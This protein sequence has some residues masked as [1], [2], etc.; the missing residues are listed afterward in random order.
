MMNEANVAEQT[1]IFDAPLDSQEQA[2]IDALLKMHRNNAALTQQLALDASR[3]VATSQ[4]RLTRQKEA[5]FF[6]RLTNAISGKTS[7]N[8]LLNQQAMLQMQRFSWHYLQQLQQQNLLNAQSIAVI[9]NNLGTMNDYIIETRG[10]LERAVDKID[11]RLRR[12]E[13]STDFSNWALN[14][15]ANKRRFKSIPKGLLI[16]RLTYDFMRLHKDIELTR[17]DVNHLITTLQSLDVD[18]D[19][20][21]RLLDFVSELIDQ[22]ELTGIEQYHATIELSFD[23]HTVDS[24]FIQKNISGVGFNALYFLAEHYERIAALIGDDELCNNDEAREKLISKFFGNELPGLS[25]KYSIRDLICEI[26]G[27]G[28]LCIDIYKDAH[29]LN[30]V[31]ADVEEAFQPEAVKLVSSLPDIKAHTFLDTSDDESKRNYLLLLA[32]CVDHAASLNESAREFIALL[33]EKAGLPELQHEI[34]KLADNPRTQF[35]FQ[36]VMQ[37]LLDNDDKKY[38]WLLDAF[39]LLTLAQKPIENPQIK[40][41]LGILKLAQLKECLPNLLVIVTGSDGSQVLDAAIR[42]TAHT[43]GWKNVIRYREIRFDKHFADSRKR[44]SSASW[45]ATR[46]LLEM[47][48]IYSKGMEHAVFITISD[49]G[50]LSSF[51]DK[52]AASICRMGRSSAI[53]S[54]NEFRKKASDLISEHCSALSHANSQISRW[55]MPSFDYKDEIGHSSFDLNNS[56]E[57]DDWGDQFKEY[58]DRVDNTLN[59]F[60]SACER[61]C[62]Q[63]GYFIE[64]DF[65]HSVVKIEE[66]KR[67]EWLRQQELERLEQKSVSIVKDGREQSFSIEWQKVEHPPCAP[68]QITHIRTDGKIWLAVAHID[69]EDFFYRSEDGVHWQQVQL[70]IPSMKVWVGEIQIVNGMWIVRNRTLSQRTRDEGCYYSN[71]A[72]NWCYSVAPNVA[73][74]KGLSLNQGYLS[75]KNLIYFNGMWLWAATQY[76]RYSYVEEGFFSDSTK[77]DTYAKLILFRADTLD[78][79]WQRWDQSPQLSEGVKIE[80]IGALPGRNALLAFCEYDYSYARNKKRPETPP[81]VMYYGAAKSWQNCEWGGET[82]YRYYSTPPVFAEMGNELL[83][84]GSEILASEKG[85]E[86]TLRAPKISADEHFPLPGLSLSLFTS[87]GNR[88]VIRVSQ[89]GKAFKDLLLE[90]GNWSHLAANEQGILGVHYANGHEETMLR[91]GRYICR[92]RA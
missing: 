80:S 30:V 57:N 42:S 82:R 72:L 43:Q 39:F 2:A 74:T 81:F 15:L 19:E 67:A 8:Q 7:E 44:L 48:D 79:P 31:A 26:I 24:N 32:L 14:V 56:A 37:T 88:S 47:S 45:A 6:K 4:E 13:N 52:A 50:L 34:V 21:V 27:G 63:L 46:L 89:D 61:A 38:T 71:D 40:V 16:L 41:I 10:F 9:R 85:Y 70:D 90:E 54:L 3:L 36:S 11:Q 83:H 77:T 1:Q 17:R 12:V 60:S 65:D 64:G 69:S 20:H 53:S 5:G 76:Q 23:G 49:G 18:C 92:A 58:Y 51:A 86:W 55:N 33:A 91:V 68:E 62:E 87:K 59:A 84:V 28:Q 78:G 35:E 75:Y 66:Q 22:I 73:S 25:A 29:R